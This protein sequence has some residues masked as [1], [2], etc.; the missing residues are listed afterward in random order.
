MNPIALLLLGRSIVLST[1]NASKSMHP[2]VTK[3]ACDIRQW[4]GKRVAVSILFGASFL[5]AQNTDH[6]YCLVE[7]PVRRR[8]LH[9]PAAQMTV[10]FVGVVPGPV[11]RGRRILVGP[12]LPGC[13]R[14]QIHQR[15]SPIQQ[16]HWRCFRWA[17]KG[18]FSTCCCYRPL[19]PF[20]Y[21]L[22]TRKNE[23]TEGLLDEP[24]V[25][26]WKWKSSV[27]VAAIACFNIY[28]ASNACHRLDLM[29]LILPYEQSPPGWASL[30]SSRRYME[31]TAHQLK[32]TSHS[33]WIKPLR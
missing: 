1:I 16:I 25:F 21:F 11:V 14:L 26:A 33:V 31:T 17:M 13:F 8:R 6:S 19:L 29:L 12:Y 32:T 9:C 24:R 28:E 7:I 30:V 20:T 5:S 3:K 18:T 23:K 27:K 4:K 22:S 15:M 2:K 10:G